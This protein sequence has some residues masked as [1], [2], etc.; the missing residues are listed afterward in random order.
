MEEIERTKIT[1]EIADQE[2]LQKNNRVKPL[3]QNVGSDHPVFDR[4]DTFETEKSVTVRDY[5]EVPAVEE[6]EGKIESYYSQ[7]TICKL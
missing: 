7:L 6:D 2:Y 1:D 5:T 4:K 3:V